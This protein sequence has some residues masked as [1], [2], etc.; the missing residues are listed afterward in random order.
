VSLSCRSLRFAVQSDAEDTAE[1][2]EAEEKA[3][4]EAAQGHPAEEQQAEEQD[5]VELSK[6]SLEL[7]ERVTN[8][9]SVLD[10]G[11]VPLR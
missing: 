7:D 3:A 5:V 8:L 2:Q 4:D 6:W 1:E 11:L 10:V 9:V